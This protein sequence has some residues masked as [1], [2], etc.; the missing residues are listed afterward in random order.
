MLRG[1]CPYLLIFQ[2]RAY[3][4]GKLLIGDSKKPATAVIKSFAKIRN[5]ILAQLTCCME[6]DLLHHAWKVNK[7]VDCV[8][9]ASGSFHQEFLVK[10]LSVEAAC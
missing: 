10:D 1:P 7:T 5:T 6:A 9:R 8:M 4:F 2:T 3:C